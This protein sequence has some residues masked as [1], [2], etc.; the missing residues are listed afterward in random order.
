[1]AI[2]DS[3]SAPITHYIR[4]YVQEHANEI[5]PALAAQLDESYLGVVTVNRLTLRVDGHEDQFN[6]SLDD[7]AILVANHHTDERPDS[8]SY[9]NIFRLARAILKIRAAEYLELNPISI[10]KTI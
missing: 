6:Q 1:M 3:S 10:L 2:I 9:Q 7:A 8:G 4:Q 5:V